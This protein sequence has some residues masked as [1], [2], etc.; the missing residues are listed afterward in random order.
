MG[1]GA[2]RS[3]KGKQQEVVLVWVRGTDIEALSRKHRVNVSFTMNGAKALRAAIDEV[4]GSE[5]RCSDS[6]I[7]SCATSSKSFR[8]TSGTKP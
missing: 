5:Q 1:G 7:T 6:G 2:G 8:G 3:A 4:F